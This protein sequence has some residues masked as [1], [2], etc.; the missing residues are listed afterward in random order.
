MKPLG[1]NDVQ[2]CD[3]KTVN[4]HGVDS[5]KARKDKCYCHF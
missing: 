3:A 5:R 4:I 2:F 1:I